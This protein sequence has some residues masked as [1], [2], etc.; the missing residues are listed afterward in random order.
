ML[1]ISHRGNLNGINKDFENKP[2]YIF[3]ALEK[4]FN[5]EVDIWYKKNNFYLGHDEPNILVE[6]KFISIS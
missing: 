3:N 1:Y 6:Q 4:K 2:S 5:V